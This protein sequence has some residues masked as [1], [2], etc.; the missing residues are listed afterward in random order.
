MGRPVSGDMPIGLAGMGTAGRSSGTGPVAGRFVRVGLGLGLA[1][2][3]GEADAEAEGD[4]DVEADGEA[5]ALAVGEVRSGD[6]EGVDDDD[7]DVDGLAAADALGD[8]AADSGGAVA[9]VP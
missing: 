8:G 7:D 5:E 1:L 4:A 2:A 3:S 6:G 9:V